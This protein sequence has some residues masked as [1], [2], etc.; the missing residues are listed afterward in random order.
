MSRRLRLALASIAC[1]LLLAALLLEGLCRLLPVN[2]TLRSMP[3]DAANPVLRFE[4]NRSTLWSKG[5][6]FCLTNSVR[7]NNWGFINNQDYLSDAPGPLVAVIGD[8]YIEALMLPWEQTGQGLLAKALEDRARVYSFARSGAPLSQYLAYAQWASGRFRPDRLVV[9]V[10]GNDYDESLSVYKSTPGFH[11]Y[12]DTP[13]GLELTRVDYHPGLGVKLISSSRLLMYLF[14]NLKVM[15]LPQ[16]IRTRFFSSATAY[17]GNTEAQAE[18]WRLEQSRRAVDKALEE[19]PAR[20]GL[21]PA[22]ICLVVNGLIPEVYSAPAR[23]AALAS[24]AGQMNAYLMERARKLGYRVI[25][26][27]PVLERDYDEHGQRF[28]LSPCDGHW[29]ARA[30]R[31]FAKAVLDSGFLGDLRGSQ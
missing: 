29:N 25:D 12:T 27:Q 14:T 19:F 16:L 22:R 13:A 7:A 20:T 15:E 24:Y 1:G 8:S 10:V 11:Y 23:K 18:P 6:D 17:V 4:P 31:L 2:E 28:D 9:L 26:M 21:P 5:P 3:V 30:H